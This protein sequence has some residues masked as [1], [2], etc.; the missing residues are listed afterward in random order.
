[1]LL[2]AHRDLCVFLECELQE[3]PIYIVFGVHTDIKISSAFG[4]GKEV[5]QS[6]VYSQ[7]LISG[8]PYLFSCL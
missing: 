3:S 1:M 6:T 2:V 7:D 4:W 5:K 8:F